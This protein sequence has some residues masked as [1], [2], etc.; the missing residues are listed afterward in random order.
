[1][2]KWLLMV[3]CVAVAG[4]CFRILGVGPEV[5]GWLLLI[6]SLMTATALLIAWPFLRQRTPP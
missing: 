2:L 3:L 5:L 4:G 6:L 1:M